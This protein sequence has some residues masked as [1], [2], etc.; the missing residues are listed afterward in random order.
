MD[1]ILRL[2]GIS[3]SFPGVQAL[4]SVKMELRRG[5]VHGLVGE[6][7]AGKST[8]MKILAGVYQPDEGQIFLEGC[9]VVFLNPRQ[10]MDV[11][12]NIIHQELSLLSQLNAYENIFWTQLA[13]GNGFLTES[14]C[15]KQLRNY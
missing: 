7:G 13:K 2:E 15:E 14:K 10:A 8:L 4:S 3:K 5:E 9:P 6:N 1:H 12:I 11:G